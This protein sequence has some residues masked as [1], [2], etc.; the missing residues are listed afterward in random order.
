[1]Q[2]SAVAPLAVPHPLWPALLHCC[3]WQRWA[4]RPQGWPACVQP[5]VA[6]RR[7]H[8]GPPH[9][10]PEAHA[11]R[12]FACAHACVGVVIDQIDDQDTFMRH[13]T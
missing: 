10:Y 8:P 7:A 11:G 3:R 4:P 1:M 5:C 9:T 13:Y 2:C 6:P 12:A